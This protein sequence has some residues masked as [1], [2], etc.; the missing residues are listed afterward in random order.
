MIER[1][2][3]R[4]HHLEYVYQLIWKL[5]RRLIC[6]VSTSDRLTHKKRH[7]DTCQHPNTS[8]EY[9]YSDHI[10]MQIIIY[11]VGS[12][13]L[14]RSLWLMTAMEKLAR[15]IMC[16][17][18]CAWHLSHPSSLHITMKNAK[19]FNE[20]FTL[21][22][23]IGFIFFNEA[24]WKFEISCF[25]LESRHAKYSVFPFSRNGLQMGCWIKLRFRFHRNWNFVW[26]IFC[27]IL[28]IPKSKCS[29]RYSP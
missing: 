6:S 27:F 2:H 5:Q 26:C 4:Q 13:F 24:R 17:H 23:N 10:S 18:F 21:S 15:A 3:W 19:Y 22:V 28:F 29:F 1:E 11:F 25:M 16:T 8:S 7:A 12:V 20:I 9:N 14:H